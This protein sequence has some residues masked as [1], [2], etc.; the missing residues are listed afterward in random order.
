MNTEGAALCVSLCSSVFHAAYKTIVSILAFT[1]ISSLCR[2]YNKIKNKTK[3]LRPEVPK[4]THLSALIL[5]ILSK[6]L[7]VEIR[8]I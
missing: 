3:A 5:I 2:N 1:D 6:C 7:S 4:L 8:L